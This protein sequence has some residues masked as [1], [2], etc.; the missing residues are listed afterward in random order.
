MRVT[1]RFAVLC[2]LLGAVAACSDASGPGNG[3]LGWTQVDAA[4]PFT[5]ALDADGTAY[6]WGD[7]SQG[8]LG[9]TASAITCDSAG[10]CIEPTPLPVAGHQSWTSF[11]AEYGATC[12]V[13][14]GFA[15]CW[16][17]GPSG[18]LGSGD[19]EPRSFR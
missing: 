3:F 14:G 11:S 2:A 1:A 10:P 18:E 16:G 15:Y 13:T 17:L 4:G 8:Q 5:C 6:C 7:A 19:T 12:G 9:V